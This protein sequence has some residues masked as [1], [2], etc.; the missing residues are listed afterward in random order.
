METRNLSAKFFFHSHHKA[1]SDG[2][3]VR[4]KLSDDFAFDIQAVQYSAGVFLFFSLSDVI[5]YA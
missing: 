1:S 5:F 3:Y 4:L 2:I